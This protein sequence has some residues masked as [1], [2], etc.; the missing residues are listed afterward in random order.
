LYTFYQVCLLSTCGVQSRQNLPHFKERAGKKGSGVG[1]ETGGNEVYRM[2]H[3]I[4]LERD[5]NSVEI[6]HH[7]KKTKIDK[8]NLH[9][10]IR[11][12]IW[13]VKLIPKHPIY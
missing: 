6:T 5:V 7:E 3:P 4:W 2:P 13:F 9:I 8:V 1:D 12:T 10:F 11:Y